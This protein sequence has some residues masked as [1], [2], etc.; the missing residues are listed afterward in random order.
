MFKNADL[1]VSALH[2]TG[3]CLITASLAPEPGYQP[4]PAPAL[5]CMPT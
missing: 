2:Y 3:S 5:G 1:S 4:V